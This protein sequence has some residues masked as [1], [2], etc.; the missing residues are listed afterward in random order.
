MS[1]AN[2]ALSPSAGL[3]GWRC[4]NAASTYVMEKY[5]DQSGVATFSAPTLASGSTYYVIVSYG[6]AAL[7][8]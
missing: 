4:S 5:Y 2:S 6:T 1:E 8:E 3:T 7:A